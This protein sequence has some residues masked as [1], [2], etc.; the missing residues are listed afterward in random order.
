MKTKMF[1]FF[2][3][4]PFLSLASQ[5]FMDFYQLFQLYFC[6]W[7]FLQSYSQCS[8]IAWFRFNW[9][10]W[11]SLH[12]KFA[13]QTTKAQKTKQQQNEKPINFMQK[14]TKFSTHLL[15]TLLLWASFN[16]FRPKIWPTFNFIRLKIHRLTL[17]Q[18]R[19]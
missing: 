14:L 13:N 6:I 19:I 4:V 3:R 2:W 7:C 8:F 15:W 1:F 12:K 17:W 10:F 9:K 5:F 18:Y 16:L 11:T